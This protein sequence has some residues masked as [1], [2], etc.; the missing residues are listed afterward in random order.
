MKQPAQLIGTV[1]L[2]LDANRKFYATVSHD[3][4]TFV[5]GPWDTRDAC[6]QHVACRLSEL[7]ALPLAHAVGERAPHTKESLAATETDP[8]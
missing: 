7:S 8:A 3:Q 5:T 2:V 4:G 6:F 1:A